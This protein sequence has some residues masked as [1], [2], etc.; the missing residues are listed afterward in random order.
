MEHNTATAIFGLHMSHW[1][2]YFCLCP[3]YKKRQYSYY[4]DMWV[5]IRYVGQYQDINILCEVT[6][7]SSK[8]TSSH[9]LIDKNDDVSVDDLGSISFKFCNIDS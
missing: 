9:W 8:V 5:Q 1:A 7:V 4:Q 6:M 3:E 2:D